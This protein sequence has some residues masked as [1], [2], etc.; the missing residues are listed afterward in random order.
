MKKKKKS[1]PQLLL[2]QKNKLFVQGQLTFS[3]VM[4]IWNHS[5]PLLKSLAQIKIDLSEVVH[6]DS[7]GLA[8]LLEWKRWAKL[9]HKSVEFIHLP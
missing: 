6:C 3:T 2:K 4:N 8:L 1:V 5:K 7:A 9:N